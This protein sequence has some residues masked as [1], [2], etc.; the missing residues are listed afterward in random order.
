MIMS[1]WFGRAGGRNPVSP[2]RFGTAT[3][4]RDEKILR[5]DPLRI[6][7]VR[8][9]D[10]GTNDSECQMRPQRSNPSELF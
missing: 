2:T 6:G 4:S 9:A 10:A 1:R 5:L 3:S 8:I 7:A